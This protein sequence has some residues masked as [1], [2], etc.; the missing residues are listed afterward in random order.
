MWGW[1]WWNIRYRAISGIELWRWL[2]LVAMVIALTIIEY[3]ERQRQ[4][5][6]AQ[7]P[8]TISSPP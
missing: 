3:R 2:V 1:I 7:E 6:E 5:L 8:P 4:K